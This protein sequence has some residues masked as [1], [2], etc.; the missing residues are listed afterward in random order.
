[1][2]TKYLLPCQCGATQPI[3]IA[4]AGQTVRCECGQSL[5]VP[6]MRDIRRLEPVEISEERKAV[7]T[8]WSRVQGSLFAVGLAVTV[9]SLII[10]VFLW[11]NRM[12]LDTTKPVI[13]D[14]AQINAAIDNFPPVE[15]WNAWQEVEHNGL[16]PWYPPEYVLA[17]YESTALLRWIIALLI[18]AACGA[19]TTITAFFL[20]RK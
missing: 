3:D 10:A 8:D 18:I 11:I 15:V 5:D 9:I 19:A 14:T 20:P 2:A 1:M 7:A 13:G 12:Q 6:T 17:R 4:Q 16:G